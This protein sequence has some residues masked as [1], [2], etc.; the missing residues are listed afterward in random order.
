MKTTIEIPEKL[1]RQAK[2]RA[3]LEGVSLRE[4]FLRGLQ[5]ALR[6]P[7]VDLNRPRTTFPLIRATQSQARLTDKQVAAAQDT[8]EDLL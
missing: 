2:M 6:S 8:D 5:L 7:S 1:F 4:L 3:A